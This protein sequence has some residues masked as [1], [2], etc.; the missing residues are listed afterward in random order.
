VVVA[1]F[2][3]I[4]NVVGLF[5]LCLALVFLFTLGLQSAVS[6][7]FQPTL[8]LRSIGTR[9]MVVAKPRSERAQ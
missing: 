7:I 9:R 8:E 3:P 1:R 5:I 2:S 4:E 6:L